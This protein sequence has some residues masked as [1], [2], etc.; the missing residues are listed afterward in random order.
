MS[1]D[2]VTA[3]WNEETKYATWGL[4]QSTLV[5]ICTQW[6]NTTY[7]PSMT[8]HK[9]DAA[10]PIIPDR[11]VSNTRWPGSMGEM[12]DAAWG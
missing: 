9:D 12:E 10:T 8:A 6:A 11:P 5:Q 3:G 4:S 7:D 1:L 2:H